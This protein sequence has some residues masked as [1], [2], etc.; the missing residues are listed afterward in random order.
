VCSEELRG[1]AEGERRCGLG[2]AVDQEHE[3]KFALRLEVRRINDNAVLRKAIRSLP[4]EFL[5]ASEIP[6]RDLLIEVRQAAR[7]AAAGGRVI[8][9]VGMGRRTAGHRQRAVPTQRDIGPETPRGVDISKVEL[10][11]RPAARLDPQRHPRAVMRG[12]EQRLA[13]GG[14][15]RP[16]PSPR[17]FQLLSACPFP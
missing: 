3:R 16:Q 13:I 2:S 6:R 14:P 15:D 11:R 12:N 9:F 8:D 4:A 1:R 17:K 7:R 10:P 5:H